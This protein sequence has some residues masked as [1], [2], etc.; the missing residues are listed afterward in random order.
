M[1]DMLFKTLPEVM[2]MLSFKIYEESDKCAESQVNASNM[3]IST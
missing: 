2:F 1:Y 3:Q